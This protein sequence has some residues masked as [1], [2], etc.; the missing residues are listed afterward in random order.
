MQQFFSL[1]SRRLFTDQHV[2]GVFPPSSGAQCLQSQRL[3][4]PSYRGDS[5]AVSY[6][7]A[8]F[9][10][11]KCFYAFVAQYF[12]VPSFSFCGPGSVVGIASGYGPVGP[13]I[14]SRWIETF[15]TCPD[16]P[17]DPPSLLYNGYRVFPVGKER[18]G[19]DA[20]PSPTSSVVVMKE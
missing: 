16:L 15:R 3:I 14:E 19:R 8:T 11:V 1:L 20:E 9:E 2:S 17:W 12:V 5:R 4:L 13:G 6:V 18:P 10:G 7:S